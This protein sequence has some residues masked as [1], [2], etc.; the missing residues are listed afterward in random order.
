MKRNLMTMVL[1][2][3]VLFSASALVGCDALDDLLKAKVSGKVVDDSGNPI[4]GAE[5]KLYGLSENTDFVEGGDPASAEAYIIPEKIVASNN[6]KATAITG[7]DGTFVMEDVTLDAFLATATKENCSVDFLGFKEDSGILNLDSLL[8]PDL[9]SGS[10][11]FNLDNFIITCATPPAEPNPEDNTE[12]YEPPE[13]DPPSCDEA[14][15]TAAGGTCV[16]GA[17]EVPDCSSDADCEAGMAGSYCENPGTQDATC[18]PPDENEIIPPAESLWTTFKITDDEENVLG[19]AS[20]QSVAFTT[21]KEILRVYGSYT[22]DEKDAYVMVQTGS[23]SCG[24]FE[25]KLDVIQVPLVD[26]SLQGG[27]G[28]YVEVYNYGGYMKI[29]LTT[30]PANGEGDRSFVVEV[31]EEC[32]KPEQPFTAI[33]TWEVEQEDRIDIDLH[34]WNAAEEQ[35]YYGSKKKDWGELDLDDR[36]GPGPEVFT[37]L[38]GHEADGPYIIK[39]RYFS[40]R[41]D[42]VNCKVRIIR[43]LPTGGVEDKSYTFTLTTPKEV[44]DIGQFTLTE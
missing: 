43:V 25:P 24:D 4:E 21:D 32:Q 39:A 16:D 9:E 27:K 10:T 19:D 38:P 28:D 30:N 7:A 26:S 11:D 12:P 36:K 3:L 2:V 8:K 22:G 18:M 20:T 17:C 35:C 34:V 40:G 14:T 31:G 42:A 23:Q 41:S 13:P 6:T 15:C 29:S 33:L 1:A 5:V 37:V 44:Y